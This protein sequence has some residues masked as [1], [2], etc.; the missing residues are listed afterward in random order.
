M[1]TI[2]PHH[3]PGCW[4]DRLISV[5]I[6]LPVAGM[7]NWSVVSQHTSLV[8]VRRPGSKAKTHGLNSKCQGGLKCRKRSLLPFILHTCGQGCAEQKVEKKNIYIY[9]FFLFIPFIS[10]I[11]GIN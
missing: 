8:S 5:C 10:I 1:F 3:T 2:G 9:I 7:D 4:R 11:I 6:A